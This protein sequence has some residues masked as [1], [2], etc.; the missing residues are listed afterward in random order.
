MVVVKLE[1]MEKHPITLRLYDVSGSCL[2]QITSISNDRYWLDM[3]TYPAG[4]Y[5]VKL[6]DA[7]NKYRMRK[8]ILSKPTY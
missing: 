4:C 8:I 3:S 6:S 7:N 1:N 5:F 2:K